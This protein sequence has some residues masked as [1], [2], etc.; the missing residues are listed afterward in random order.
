MLITVADRGETPQSPYF[1]TKL[2]PEGPKK[3]VSETAPPFFL[4]VW[5][6]A[7]P[8]PYLKVWIWDWIKIRFFF[9]L[10]CTENVIIWMG[11]KSRGARAAYNMGCILF[12]LQVPITWRVGGL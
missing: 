5:M 10:S 12:R 8:P 9:S 3:I 4:R 6:T 1:Q 11:L 2:R 7:P